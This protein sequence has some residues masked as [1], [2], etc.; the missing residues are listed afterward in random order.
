MKSSH[1]ANLFEIQ[2][3]YGFNIDEIKDFSSNVNP[4]GPSPKAMTKLEKILI[5]S[6]YI[7]TQITINYYHLLKN[8]PTYHETKSCLHLVAL[9]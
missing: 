7:L 6:E 5:K 9:I 2:K 4:L 8:T 1:G 3:E